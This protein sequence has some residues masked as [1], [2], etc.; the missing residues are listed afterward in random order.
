VSFFCENAFVTSAMGTLYC[1]KHQVDIARIRQ[2][3]TLPL[4]IINLSSQ[5]ADDPCSS[6]IL[7]SA[8][9]AVVSSLTR[10]VGT[11]LAARWQRYPEAEPAVRV[12]AVAPGPVRTP[13]LLGIMRETGQKEADYASRTPL[14]RLA[15]PEEVAQVILFLADEQR[16]SY[17]TGTVVPVDGGSSAASF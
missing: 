12:N 14:G 3:R 15:R 17:V 11:Q 10:T 1:L 5:N 16:S 8:G 7:Y 6:A 4:S 9:K 2:P 13:L